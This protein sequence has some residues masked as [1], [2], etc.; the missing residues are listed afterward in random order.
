MSPLQPWT[1]TVHLHQDVQKGDTS[2]ANYAIGLGALTAGDMQVPQVYRD[3]K[4]FFTA[5]YLTGGLRDLLSE[6]LA[7]LNGQDGDRVMQL[8]S[9]FG[10]GKS[11]TLTALYHAALH[12]EALHQ[13]PEAIDLP[14]PGQVRVAVF[15]GEKFDI[16]GRSVNGQ[17]T[18]TMWG[19]LAA[20][21]G[22]YGIVA[23]HDEHRIAPGGDRVAEMLGTG[24]TLILL[25]EVLKYLI[26]SSGEV[27]K[28]AVGDTTLGQLTQEFLQ[29]LST[30]VARSPRS[31]MVYSLQA[32]AREA[33][34]DSALLDSLDHLVSRVDAKREPVTGDE[35]LPVLRRRLLVETPP[36]K[37]TQ[38]TA[39]EF[40]SQIT[41]M[42][43]AHALDEQTQQDA[44]DEKLTLQERIA[45]AYPFNPALID[46]MRERWASLPGFQ[47]TRGALRFLS[48]CLHVLRRDQKA[49]YLLG[50][51]E[52]PI[53]DEQVARAFFTEVG[54][55][56]P[57]KAVMAS[58]FTGPNARI[59]RIDNRLAN[60]HPELSQI[61]PAMRLG[62][63][64]LAFSFGG[65]L[66]ADDEGG[67]PMGSGAT[68]SELLEAVV[69]PGFDSLTAQAVLKQL[70]D[71]C[72]YLHFDGLR[73]VFKTTPNITHLIEQ[74]KVKKEAVKEAIETELSN[75][76]KGRAG[77][78][79]WPD[80][81][82]K[83]P[84]KELQFVLAYLPLDFAYQTPSQQEVMAIDYLEHYGE[85]PRHY[86]NGLALVIPAKKQVEALR[87]AQRNLLAIE[88]VKARKLQ[89]NLTASQ[90]KQLDTR[91]K[92]E[93]GAHEAAMRK[94]YQLIWLPR[95]QDG[96]IEIDEVSS[97]GRPLVANTL[98]EKLVELLT[99]VHPKR[100]F[101]E[102]TPNKLAELMRLGDQ[103]GA[104]STGRIVEAFFSIPDFPRLLNEG[105]IR[106][107]IA[108]GVNSGLFGYVR[109]GQITAEQLAEKGGYLVEATEVRIKEDINL[110]DIDL[111]SAFIV[112]PLAIA[113]Q[114]PPVTSDESGGSDE[115][116]DSGGLGLPWVPTGGDHIDSDGPAQTKKTDV[117]L[118]MQLTR[119]QLYASTNALSNLAEQSGSIQVTVSAK[120]ADGFDPNWLR[121][122]VLEPLEEADVAVEEMD[123][124]GG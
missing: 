108:D 26:R 2:I 39:V 19:M 106:Q 84:H 9:P 14:N 76:L 111:S 62:T 78:I 90:V 16:M 80:S 72:L 73:Y 33:F 91:S 44:E 102:L 99:D 37:V 11:H 6:V 12:P 18:Q 74:A 50:P 58:D 27:M 43:K 71:N 68:E 113:A 8:H 13:L 20:Q 61:R 35:I 124:S 85:Q 41:K 56:D 3:P 17:P 52:I 51:G 46:I 47:R 69:R 96:K 103:E 57:F 101:K 75:R 97:E 4:H 54:Q 1:S 87:L 59:K 77:A 98:H 92:E 67:E 81:S 60:E 121:N 120:K 119:Q 45:Q 93:A 110:S 89:L 38:A 64:I 53:E 88:K 70:R 86:R 5:T 63:A 24:P 100:V 31:V 109:P 94:L 25:D 21:L 42:K 104:V 23:Y 122:A 118:R 10:G 65:L 29:T 36:D 83:I 66:R 40:A 95:I 32:S 123:E 15:D 22:C 107:A 28:L 114:E 30:E 116:Q 112:D 48:I 49:D 115:T 34:G 105:V 7:R 117:R 55:R 79:L 82:Q